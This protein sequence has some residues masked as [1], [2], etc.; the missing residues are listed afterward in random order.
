MQAI[1]GGISGKTRFKLFKPCFNRFVLH[2]CAR[3][4]SGLV[5]MLRKKR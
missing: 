5:S 3:Q 2:I 4:W 1:F